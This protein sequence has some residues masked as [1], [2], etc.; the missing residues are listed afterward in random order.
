MNSGPLL[1]FLCGVAVSAAVA[2]WIWP[3]PQVLQSGPANTQRIRAVPPTLPKARIQRPADVAPAPMVAVAADPQADLATAIPDLIRLVRAGDYLAMEQRYLPPQKF[4][5]LSD[6]EKA[7]MLE[8]MQSPRMQEKMQ[9]S[10]Q[11]L[12]SI[13][14]ATPVFNDTGEI[15][16]FTP[17]ALPGTPAK[18]TFI[19]LNGLWYLGD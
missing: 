12:E 2:W 4:A 11:A 5:R 3:A 8:E 15:A 13:Q 1:G 18:M 7:L 16:T 14:G 10:L 17:I 9:N 6:G 19:R